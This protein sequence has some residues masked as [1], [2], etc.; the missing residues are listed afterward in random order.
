MNRICKTLV[1]VTVLTMGFA[2][3][4]D[5]SE[6]E[7]ESSNGGSSG[8]TGGHVSSVGGS[9]K[10]GTFSLGGKNSTGGK[11]Q[12]GVAGNDTQTIG[13]SSQAGSSAIGGVATAG[14]FSQ[15]GIS[16]ATGGSNAQIGGSIAGSNS[17]GGSS[18]SIGGT[19]TAGSS[20]G[21]TN[22]S[23]NSS[24]GGISSSIGGVNSSGSTSQAGST[25]FGG[26]TGVGGSFAAGASSGGTSSFGGVA[27]IG[28]GNSTGGT[29]ISI[30]GSSSIAGAA[31]STSVCVTGL[32]P[33]IGTSEPFTCT[34]G[35]VRDTTFDVMNADRGN[36]LVIAVDAWGYRGIDYAIASD[37]GRNYAFQ[38]SMGEWLLI[39][40][41][42]NSFKPMLFREIEG[43]VCVGGGV[44]NSVNGVMN[45][46]L[47]CLD[48]GNWVE[49]NVGF[50]PT[51][52]P[53]GA[54][55]DGFVVDIVSGGQTT[56]L[57]AN[58][59]DQVAWNDASQIFLKTQNG[60]WSRQVLPLTVGLR[61][62]RAWVHN[63]CDAYAVGQ[64]GDEAVVL[65]YDGAAW[66][67]LTTIPSGLFT[68]NS[69]HG[70]G[71][72]IW[73]GGSSVVDTNIYED[74]A[75]SSSDLVNWQTKTLS[76]T[77]SSGGVTSAIWTPKL[78][79]AL[80][81]QGST[82]SGSTCMYR[83]GNADVVSQGTVNDSFVFNDDEYVM[84]IFRSIYKSESGYIV[85]ADGS[86][87]VGSGCRSIA[88]IYHQRSCQ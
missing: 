28:G 44:S 35:F 53:S 42:P 45:G 34:I 65:H 37:I 52:C 39:T 59:F 77:P 12:G 25:S 68:F 43:K 5:P 8:N 31:G 85:A 64:Y 54:L 71:N 29:S 4:S 69:V 46:Q 74:V 87:L 56:V 67:R 2:C 33:I 18:L 75:I 72:E 32:D 19:S 14:T 13:G 61:L 55:N 38:R 88:A 15:G 66:S 49:Q 78:G 26:M 1:F 83:G 86:H 82:I 17:I 48:G 62:H 10:G 6:S 30:A 21:G 7:Q 23:G 47:L 22:V 3:S 73:I 9:S 57:I 80:I 51:G 81:V 84:T 58:G 24:Q 60:I 41:L 76:S 36:D 50:C 70:N 40:S 11:S 27:S 16:V 20:S 63:D 79:A